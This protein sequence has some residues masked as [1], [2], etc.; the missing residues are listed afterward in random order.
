VIEKFK[1]K[2]GGVTPDEIRQCFANRS[3]VFLVDSRENHMTNPLTRWFISQ[4]NHGRKLKICFIPFNDRVTIKTV[5]E[6]NQAEIKLYG[7][8]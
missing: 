1:T 3:G 6:P 4:T 2:H 7:E 8:N 5:Y